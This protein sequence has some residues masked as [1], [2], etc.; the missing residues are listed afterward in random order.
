MTMVD[1]DRMKRA[2]QKAD[3]KREFFE[4][5]VQT[6]REPLL[7][8]DSELRIVSANEAFYRTF[9]T[10]ARQTVGLAVYELG[11]GQWDIP[12]LRRL[13]EE[14]LPHDTVITDFKVR[15]DFPRIGPREFSLSARRIQSVEKE[16]EMILLSFEDVSE[17]QV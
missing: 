14:V 12:E 1:I 6:V 10:Q 7:V 8:L 17:K 11:D 15:G 5:I 3:V 2:E 9:A 4:A 13:L 16:P